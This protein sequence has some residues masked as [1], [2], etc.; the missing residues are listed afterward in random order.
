MTGPLRGLG[1]LAIAAVLA[2]GCSVP[3]DD[4]ATVIASSDLPESLRADFTTTTTTLQAPIS[5]TAPVYLLT[6]QAETTRATVVEVM[7]EVPLNPTIT[8]VMSRLFGEGAVTSEEEA[9]NYITTLSEFELLSATRAG[10]LAVIDIVNLTPEGLPSDQP[11]EGDLIEVAAQVVWTA[12]AI[13]GVN[14]VQI[15]INGQQVTIPTNNSDT[16]VGAPVTRS[17]YERFD[18]EFVPPSTSTT[19]TTIATSSSTTDP[20]TPNPPTTS[21]TA[22]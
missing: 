8:D 6:R 10:D 14:R 21:S 13:D 7:R 16:E 19:T 3:S 20:G 15:L 1:I 9:A 5:T 12:T 22:P 11:Y 4:A 18:P 2:T 17:D